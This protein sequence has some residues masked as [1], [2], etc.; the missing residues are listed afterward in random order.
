MFSFW[1]P[2]A[3]LCTCKKS[4]LTMLLFL[5][6]KTP[7][8]L[9]ATPCASR[10][11][12]T[13]GWHPLP[14][15]WHPWHPV[16]QPGGQVEL[17][18]HPSGQRWT[19][20]RQPSDPSGSADV[21]I[22]PCPAFYKQTNKQTKLP[23]NKQTKLPTNKQINWRETKERERTNAYLQAEVRQTNKQNYQQTNHKK[24]VTCGLKRDDRSSRK[25]EWAACQVWWVP[26]S[27]KI[28]WFW[29]CFD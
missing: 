27:L 22:I 28:W 13:L 23:T 9:P 2:T 16:E 24:T 11:L 18:W 8:P 1:F 15:A 29:W 25:Q 26:W 12:S 6:R 5:L 7:S 10:V 20:S 21:Q 4:I 17:D 14:P 19:D 3:V